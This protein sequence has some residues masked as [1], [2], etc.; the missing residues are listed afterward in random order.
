MKTQSLRNLRSA[1]IVS[2]LLLAVG[3]LALAQNASSA[4]SA[5]V[6]HLIKF[7]GVLKDDAGHSKTGVSG[8]TFALY[9]DQQGGAPLWIE[10][11]N[12][13]TDSKGNYTVL[14]GSSKSTGLPIELFTSG[15]ERWIG[16][17]PQ[18]QNEQPRVLLVSAP[19][20]LKALDAETLGGKPLSAFQLAVPQGN[21]ATTNGAPPPEQSNEIRCAGG[22]ACKTSFFPKFSSNGGSARVNDS[23][24]TQSGTT[25][26]IAGNLS[27]SGNLNASTGQ[28]LGQTGSFTANTKNAVLSVGN[29]NPSGIAVSGVNENANGN[30]VGVQGNGPNGVVGIGTARGVTGTGLVGV[31]GEATGTNSIGVSGLGSTGVLGTGSGNGT[32]VQGTGDIG[33]WGQ[34][35][36]GNTLGVLAVGGNGLIAAGNETGDN[37][38]GVA[39]TVG[40]SGKNLGVEGTSDSVNGTG[41]YGLA[42]SPSHI[43]G[44]RGC[45]PVGV[46]GDTSSNAGGAAGLVGTADDARAIYLEN[47]SPSGVPTAFM[48]QDASGELALMAGGAGG[49][50]TINTNGAL[51]CPHALSVMAPVDSGKRRVALYA[52][53][54]PQN[55]FEDFGSGQLTGGT[56]RIA[57]DTTFAEEVN[58]GVSYHV[59]LTPHEECEGLYVSDES[60][61]GFEVHELH[62]GQSNV[63]FDYRIVALR[64]GFET[65]RSE[66]MT[67]QWKKMNALSR[68]TPEQGTKPPSI[69]RVIGKPA[70]NP[71]P[72]LSAQR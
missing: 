5:A 49:F 27:L 1:A 17:Q 38:L 25:V 50:C 28:V 54:S 24:V 20:A 35:A 11:Q 48:Q 3:L 40:N 58:T 62:H 16:V 68:I 8:I 19:Y 42:I 18:G 44:G 12:V 43:G 60:A 39:G 33:V 6:P 47:N 2:T 55:W 23:I 36:S 61:S 32:G 59:F 45:C 57:L 34:G 30:G 71:L 15:G 51:S 70:I 4:K 9:K 26:G 64:R 63:T 72:K 37:V 67:S 53:E 14:L 29:Q 56:A 21:S 41:L 31:E 46:W 10:T 13:Q 65:V 69:S 22:A 52:M 7:N 66:D